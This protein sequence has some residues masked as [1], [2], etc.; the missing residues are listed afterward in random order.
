MELLWFHFMLKCSLL[1]LNFLLCNILFSA[2]ESPCHDGERSALLQLKQSL[3]IGNC[4]TSD[5]YP[6]VESWKLKGGSNECCAWDGVECDKQTGYVI[7]LHLSKSCLHGSIS[8]NSSLF[9]LVHLR[10]LDLSLN[11][12]STSRIP[13]TM[14]DLSQLTYLNL[15]FSGFYDQIPFELSKLFSLTS[16]DLSRNPLEI[17]RPSLNNLLQNLTSLRELDLSYINISSTVPDVLANLS[18]L[19]SLKLQLCELH[20]KF[21][22]NIFTLQKL[23]VLD[24]TYNFDLSGQLPDFQLSKA[25]KLLNLEGT[26]F[27]GELPS[28]IGS[29]T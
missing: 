27:S 5:A 25:L 28:S 14:G 15:S 1:L 8:H 18:S 9:H 20:G 2:A 10:R 19:T 24:L 21:P 7:S 3:A 22:T 17:Q 6:K 29:L 13:S 12:L 23:Q 26:G 4:V 16:L 11:D